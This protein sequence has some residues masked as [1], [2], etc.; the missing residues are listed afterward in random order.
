MYQLIIDLVGWAGMAC[1]LGAYGLS[2]FKKISVDSLAYSLL[3][4]FGSAFLVIN[5]YYY[6]VFPPMVL[7]VIWIFIALGSFLKNR[8][9]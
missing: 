3:N 6:R 5:T 8:K 2:T 9:K 7:N 1:V 4:I